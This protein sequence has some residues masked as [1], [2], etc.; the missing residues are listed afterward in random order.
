VNDEQPGDITGHNVNNVWALAFPE[1]QVFLGGNEELGSFLV[2]PDGM[3]LYRFNPDEVG[4][5]NCGGE[6]AV[7]WP[8]F[9]IE[10]GK[11]P[12]GNAGIVGDLGTMERADDGTIQVTYQGM[13][14][15]YWLNDEAPGDATGQGFNDV[16]FVVRP[17]T[18]GLGGN[19]ELGDF[20][21]GPNSMSLYWFAN[22]EAGVSNC[23]DA[24]AD[25]WP[26]LL[27]QEGEIPVPGDGVTG[28]LGVIERDDGT[29]Q[30]TYSGLPLYFWVNDEAA[31]DATGH[32]VNDA[33]SVVPPT[34]EG[35][36]FDF[37]EYDFSGDN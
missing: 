35:D 1:T 30:V 24:C 11:T 15:Y 32:G 29:F 25:N 28:Q 6:C 16:W 34:A 27:I 5:S 9:I 2:G 31:G 14:L 20:L 37:M 7:N 21:V 26:P 17:Y 8:P 36:N 13:P 19:D 3:T 18:I 4:V 22:D 10:A 12:R 23:F 33:W